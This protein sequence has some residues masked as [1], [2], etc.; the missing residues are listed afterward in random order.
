VIHER[1]LS[2]RSANSIPLLI[3]IYIEDASHC[4]DHSNQNPLLIHA[5]DI[6]REDIVLLDLR[7]KLYLYTLATK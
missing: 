2:W 6:F 3:L 7:I 4:I 5:A 1:L